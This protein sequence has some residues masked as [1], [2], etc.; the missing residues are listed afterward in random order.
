MGKRFDI[1]YRNFDDKVS[2][3]YSTNSKIKV[4]V[5]GL[6]LSF[7]YQMVTINLRHK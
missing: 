6:F 1:S 4:M 5:V 3:Y 2:K 7:K